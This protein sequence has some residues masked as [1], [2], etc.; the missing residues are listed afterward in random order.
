M[1][2]F[3]RDKTRRKCKSESR[4]TVAVPVP[5]NTYTASL[6]MRQ[7]IEVETVRIGM[8]QVASRFAQMRSFRSKAK[9]MTRT[10][11]QAR[12][13]S[14]SWKLETH[15]GQWVKHITLSHSHPKEWQMRFSMRLSDST[16]MWRAVFTAVDP[17][18]RWPR[19]KDAHAGMA[20]IKIR[21]WTNNARHWIQT[22]S[23]K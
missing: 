8:D 22:P 2:Y 13:W 12:W 5:L 6:K 18:Q 15:S 21:Y 11:T 16:R 9:T 19:T 20:I 4:H 1:T 3:H 10:F 23:D 14:G 7:S 17:S